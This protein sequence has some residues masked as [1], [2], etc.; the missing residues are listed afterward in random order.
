[1]IKNSTELIAQAKECV[2]RELERCIERGK[3]PSFY[4]VFYE[5]YA[6]GFNDAKDN[7]DLK[8]DKWHYIE[9][10]G[11]PPEEEKCYIL[12]QCDGYKDTT[13]G[14][15]ERGRWFLNYQPSSFEKVLA[16]HL[17]PEIPGY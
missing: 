12:Y 14:H 13:Y 6:T 8:P 3:Q 17:L 4:E 2:R 10:E 15:Y 16:W 5:G 7:P 9:L 11:L 1:M